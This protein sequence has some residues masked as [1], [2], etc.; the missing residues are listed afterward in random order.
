MNQSTVATLASEALPAASEALPAWEAWCDGS[1]LD[2]PGYAGWAVYVRRPDGTAFTKHGS[3]CKKRSNNEAELYALIQAISS[4]PVDTSAV[5][6]SDS[7]Y[8]VNAAT[9]WRTSWTAK[10]M[11]TAGGTPVANADMVQRLWEELDRR[12]LV[13]VEWCR[14]HS[15][16]EGNELVDGL[17]RRAAEAV[18]AGGKPVRV[19][20]IEIPATTQRRHCEVLRHQSPIPS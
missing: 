9:K 3:G 5:A 4:I 10:G 8:A 14:G 11:R 1:S 18:R 12:P 6:R 20:I 19:E 16:I 7:T 17:A 15:G 2:N 13:R